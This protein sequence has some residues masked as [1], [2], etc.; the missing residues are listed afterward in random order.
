MRVAAPGM[1]ALTVMPYF[2]SAFAVLQVRPR[3]PAFAAA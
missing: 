1:I 2:A 3:I